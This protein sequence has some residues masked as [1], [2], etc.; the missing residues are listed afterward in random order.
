[1]E[2]AV[3]TTYLIHAMTIIQAWNPKEA[4]GQYWAT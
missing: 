2:I 1:M 3:N 4:L